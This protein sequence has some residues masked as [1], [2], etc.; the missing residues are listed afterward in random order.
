MQGILSIEDA[1]AKQ[2]DA[3]LIPGGGL[4]DETRLPHSWVR[5]RLD[6]A[7][8]LKEHTRYFV[9]LSRGTVHKPPPRDDRGFPVLESEASAKYLLANGLDDPGRVLIEGWSMDT[10]GNAY[11]AC[12]M[13]CEP[14]KL[15][16][17][18][19]ITSAF[20]MPKSKA[21]FEW[22]FGMSEVKFDLDFCVTKDV[23]MDTHQCMA[24]VEKERKGLATLRQST[25][26][27]VD[28]MAKLADFVFKEHAA[29]NAKSVLENIEKARKGEGID[30]G[31]ADALRSTY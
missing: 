6:A 26:P 4:D 19:L 15:C 21:I 30:D 22:V 18:L 17:S 2:F 29:Y 8:Q 31:E 16:K 23:G 10:I 20:H 5:A 7:L 9:V 24:R 11:F 14:L 25:E 1:K 3:I 12:R 13:I 27:H 28:T